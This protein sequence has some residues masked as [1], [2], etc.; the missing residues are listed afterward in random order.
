[1]GQL[2]EI[3]LFYAILEKNKKKVWAN[4]EQ[5]LTIPLAT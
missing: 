4:K 5:T 1:M 2:W 3:F